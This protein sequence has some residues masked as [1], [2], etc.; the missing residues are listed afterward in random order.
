VAVAA[1]GPADPI[2]L[3]ILIV[4]NDTA[5]FSGQAVRIA[6]A[7]VYKVISPRLFVIEP[8]ELPPS[9]M[10]D[11]DS[12]ALVVLAGPMATPMHRGAIVEVTGRPW[13]MHEVQLHPDPAGLGDLSEHELRRYQHKAVIEAAMVRTPGGIE[14]YARR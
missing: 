3:S 5:Y 10:W 6:T 11:S 9:E 7:R 4:A 2:E 14:L 1:H 8:A 13:A 12:R